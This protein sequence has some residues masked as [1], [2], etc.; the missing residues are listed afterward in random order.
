MEDGLSALSVSGSSENEILVG[1]DHIAKAAV[2]NWWSKLL[3]ILVRFLVVIYQIQNP[4][5]S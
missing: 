4:A 1:D 5:R 3:L 2:K